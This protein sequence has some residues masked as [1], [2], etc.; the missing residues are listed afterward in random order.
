MP[1]PRGP[2][3]VLC[4]VDVAGHT[5][6][7][8]PMAAAIC[9][10]LLNSVRDVFGAIPHG[11]NISP[12]VVDGALVALKAA[13]AARM[14]WY[15]QRDPGCG[16][17]PVTLEWKHEP[18]SPEMR[19]R[20]AAARDIRLAAASRDPRPERRRVRGGRRVV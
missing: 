7:G 2:A 9:N 15:L 3:D 12:A 5:V 14:R 18:L 17:D 13:I 8:A 11:A 20:L 16:V 6:L 1:A 4:S 19:A 10:Q